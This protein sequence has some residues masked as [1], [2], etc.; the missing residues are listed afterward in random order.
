MAIHFH[1]R[2]HVHVHFQIHVHVRVRFRAHFC[3]I[4]YVQVHLVY[5]YFCDHKEDLWIDGKGIL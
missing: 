2:V 4:V 5:Y 1:V 3:D